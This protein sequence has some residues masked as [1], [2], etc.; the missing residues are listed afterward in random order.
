MSRLSYEAAREV[1]Y[2][3]NKLLDSPHEDCNDDLVLFKVYSHEEIIAKFGWGTYKKNV[4]NIEYIWHELR[5]LSK[6]TFG[7]TL[8]SKSKLDS[9]ICELSDILTKAKEIQPSYWAVELYN[10]GSYEDAYFE[11]IAFFATKEEADEFCDK[12]R[13]AQENNIKVAK[14][15][16]RYSEYNDDFH[17]SVKVH[18][19]VNPTMDTVKD[20]LNKHAEFQT[21]EGEILKEL[22]YSANNWIDDLFE[23]N[24]EYPHLQRELTWVI[25]YA[26]PDDIAKNHNPRHL[27]TPD[28]VHYYI[29]AVNEETPRYYLATNRTDSHG[30]V[31]LGTEHASI[32]D[33]QKVVEN[34]LK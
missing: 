17:Q 22:E 3:L 30:W 29:G 16:G 7:Y 13:E 1:A 2:Q 14:T 24:S 21:V 31:L 8:C 5:V 32:E 28:K 12:W 20:A 10:G 23:D 25:P 9:A 34:I 6:L 26:E 33:A 4:D 11:D 18:Q 15:M 19:K 27:Y